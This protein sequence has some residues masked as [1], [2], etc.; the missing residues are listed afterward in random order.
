MTSAGW[1]TLAVAGSV[2]AAGWWFGYEE[3]V[4]LGAFGLLAVVTAL[5]WAPGRLRVSGERR[6][7]PERVA[8]GAPAEGV[9]TLVNHGR[10]RLG[11]VRL[12]DRCGREPRPVETLA[13]PPATPREVRYAVPTDRRGRIAVGPLVHVRTDPLALARRTR[14]LAGHDSILVRPRVHPLPLLPAGRAHHIEGPTSATADGGSQTFHALREYV[15]GDDLRHVHWRSTARTGELMVRQMVDVSLPRTSVVLDTREVAYG[16]DVEAFELAVE[17]A[18][19]VVSAI[20]GHGFPVA[21]VTDS[22]TRLGV[23]GGRDT[24]ALLDLLAVVDTTPAGSAAAFEALERERADGTL[25]VVTGGEDPSGSA[26]PARVAARF[27]R[28]L[29]VVCGSAVPA[30]AGPGGIPVLHA[31]NEQTLIAGWHR[32]VAR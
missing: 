14:T 32:E 16:N 11:R 15:L 9:I 20:A 1:Q 10:R 27:E 22:G 5:A 12:E 24:T 25:I 7:D 23:P 19:S 4:L 21:V 31:T 17:T 18:A 29:M 28:V 6:L 30:S 3:G 8:R 13:L 2:G 26:P